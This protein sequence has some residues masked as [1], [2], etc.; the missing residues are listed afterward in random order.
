MS[1]SNCPS[2]VFIECHAS[3]NKFG[4]WFQLFSYRNVIQ[5]PHHHLVIQ[6]VHLITFATLNP[7]SPASNMC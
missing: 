5:E 7:Y 1:S 2:K 3:Q 4:M 6:I